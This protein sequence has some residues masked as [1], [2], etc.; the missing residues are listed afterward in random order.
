MV[1]EIPLSL[2]QERS[3][4]GW[5]KTVWLKTVMWKY[6]GKFQDVERAPMYG[7]I[8][9]LG[10]KKQD[11]LLTLI[12]SVVEEREPEESDFLKELQ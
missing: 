3:R 7:L 11:Y 4:G 12:R 2:Y 9:S 1:G 10:L 6:V 5:L 8:V